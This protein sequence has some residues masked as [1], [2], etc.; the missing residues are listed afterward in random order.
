MSHF[1]HPFGQLYQ[2]ATAP[3]IFER[4]EGIYVFDSNGKRYI[5][6]TAA[7]WYA[8]VGHGRQEIA[9]A[10]SV[11]ARALA[12]YST[13]GNFS[14]QPAEELADFLSARSPMPE[15]EIFFVLGGGD[16]VQT[17]AKL[18]RRY[19]FEIGEP[20][21]IVLVSRT[22]GYHGTWGFGTSVSGIPVNRT[23]F[24][25]LVPDTIQVQWDD[26]EAVEAAIVRSGPDRVAA[27]IAEP[28]IGA[29]GVYPPP[30]GYLEAV[31]EICKRHGV[32]L[33]MDSV[34]CG[35]G[36][37]G[38]WYGVERFGVV[39]DM[40]TFAKGVTSGYLPLGGVAISGR[41]AEPFKRPGSAVFRHGP[42]YGGHPT[43]AAAGVANCK[44]LEDEHILERGALLERE[45]LGAL[46][47]A[48]ESPLVAEV[49]GG[50]GLLA[51]IELRQET[52]ESH[53]GVLD[54]LAGFA[55][56]RGVITRVLGKGLAVSPPL[57]IE[58]EE[59][60]EIGVAVA[61]ALEDLGK[62][63]G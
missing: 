32:L 28:V 50:T 62:A 25:D 63:L 7:L 19:F 24:G 35:F 60:R 10:I 13:F 40:V 3:L 18:A 41:V 1:W 52:L 46:L 30:H 31:S 61:G 37:L 17:A 22:N 55:R 26:P 58:P 12:G 47:P 23:G 8:N 16:A 11:Q 5:D 27:V 14:N 6:A 4:G 45:L 44:I 38:S 29:G 53:N 34:I 20:E 43:C 42:T 51:A 9:E 39:P 36:R 33:I 21:R 56:E 49:R 48:L 54:R 15:T 59:I 2:S 57:I